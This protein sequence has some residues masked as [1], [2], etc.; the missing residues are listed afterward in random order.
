MESNCLICDSWNKTPHAKRFTTPI[1]PQYAEEAMVVGYWLGIT[2]PLNAG[3]SVT[4][5]FTSLIKGLCEKHMK[6]IV[7]LNGQVQK[8]TAPTTPPPSRIPLSQIMANRQ[9]ANSPENIAPSV[10]SV[11]PNPTQPTDIE[12]LRSSFLDIAKACAAEFVKQHPALAQAQTV[13]PSL[14]TEPELISQMPPEILRQALVQIAEHT[15][16]PEA[17]KLAATILAHQPPTFPCPLCNKNIKAGEVHS[18]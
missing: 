18:C 17:A 4:E 15:N 12:T 6:A 16:N 1:P 13:D 9:A 5:R 7:T 14:N 2:Q 3:Q 10:P 11:T 8:R